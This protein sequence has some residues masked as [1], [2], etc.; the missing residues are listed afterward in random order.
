MHFRNTD[1]SIPRNALMKPGFT[2]FN[3]SY[4]ISDEEVDYILK[5]IEFIANNGW[6][7]LSL[8]KEIFFRQNK[9]S[10]FFFFSTHLIQ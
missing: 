9:V 5:S 6:K 10:K 1:G 3:L 2:R 4:F 7:F 8:V